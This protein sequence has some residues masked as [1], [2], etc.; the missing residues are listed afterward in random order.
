MFCYTEFCRFTAACLVLDVVAQ[1]VAVDLSYV[2]LG[3]CAPG[4]SFEGFKSRLLCRHL[5]L[6]GTLLPEA[7][8]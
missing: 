7:A 5:E 3:Q 8:K 2:L 6:I 4:S 1:V